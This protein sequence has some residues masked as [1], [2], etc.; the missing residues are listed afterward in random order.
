M[1]AV[2]Q[3]LESLLQRMAADRTDRNMMLDR[4]CESRAFPKFGEQ[5]SRAER[6]QIE[7]QIRASYEEAVEAVRAAWGEPYFEG[8]AEEC[9][10]PWQPLGWETACWD[11]GAFVASVYF[12]QE[13]NEF[14]FAVDVAV[15]RKD[16]D[17]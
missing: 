14:P 16:W 1:P 17:W 13:D 6:K 11:R 10:D 7:D 4:V 15:V 3:I 5:V 9:Y 2:L 12:G 8:K